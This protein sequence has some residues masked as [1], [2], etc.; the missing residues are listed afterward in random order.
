MRGGNIKYRVKIRTLSSQRAPRRAVCDRDTM[1]PFASLG[2]TRR[3]G[4][5]RTCSAAFTLLG[6]PPLKTPKPPYPSHNSERVEGRE[7]PG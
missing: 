4:S 2:M 7:S 1:R 6:V 5:D 3:G